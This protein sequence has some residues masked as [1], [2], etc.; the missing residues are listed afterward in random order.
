MTRQESFKRRIR[1]RMGKTGERYGAARR[2]LIEQA[3]DDH[4]QGRAWVSQPELSDVSVRSATGRGWEQWCDILDAWPG[5]T[6]GHP[7]IVAYLREEHGVDGWWAQSV[8]LGYERITGLRLPYQQPDGTFTANKT[9]TVT[10]D[11]AVL[12]EVLVDDGER[13]DLFPGLETNRRSRPTAKV[14]RLGIGRG[15]AQIALEPRDDGRVTVSISHERLGSPDEVDHWKAYWSDWL[16]AI[17][18]G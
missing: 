9:R 15:T 18:D 16:T 1:Q 12:R 5:H 17:D 8:T 13:A 4:Q 7:A 3:A 11:A 10:T 14:I 6:E 2:V